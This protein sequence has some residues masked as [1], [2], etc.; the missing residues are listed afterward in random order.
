M[1]DV[2][3]SFVAGA[4][5]IELNEQQRLNLQSGQAIGLSD[6][7]LGECVLMR[8]DVYDRVRQL[9]PDSGEWDATELRS[10]LARSSAGNGWDEPEM[11]VYDRYDEV[12]Q[13]RCS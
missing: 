7:Q 4:A 9:L 3:H 1:I 8:K 6:P 2:S 13:K 10:V 11:D 5:M 12:R